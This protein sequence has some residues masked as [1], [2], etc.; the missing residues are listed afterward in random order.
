ME[1]MVEQLRRIDA[2]LVPH[3]GAAEPI[4]AALT[5][6]QRPDS[7]GLVIGP[8]GGFAP[9]EIERFA[10]AGAR[11]VSLGPRVLRSETAGLVAAAI[12]FYHF[13]EMG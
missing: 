13:G 2:V 4:G 5:A 7:A 8:E 9:D 12:V 6:C 10:S 3:H 11:I 1:A